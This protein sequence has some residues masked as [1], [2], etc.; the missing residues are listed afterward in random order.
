MMK[1]ISHR[2]QL[3]VELNN[4]LKIKAIEEGL[5]KDQLIKKILTEY[6]SK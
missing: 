3:E 5:T 2:T 1:T 4:K 6:V